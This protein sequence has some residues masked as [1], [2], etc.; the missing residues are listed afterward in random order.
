M[1]ICR[2][3]SEVEQSNGDEESGDTEGETES[4]DEEESSSEDSDDEPVTPPPLKQRLNA[5]IG[6]KRKPA[7]SFSAL[8]PFPQQSVTPIKVSS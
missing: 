2:T 1:L 3:H 6:D 7:P 8:V 5:Q 4:G